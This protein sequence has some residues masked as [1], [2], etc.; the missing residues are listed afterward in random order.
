MPPNVSVHIVTY[1]T[2]PE[3]TRSDNPN[4]MAH[5]IASKTLKQPEE[6]NVSV[7]TSYTY[8]TESQGMLC[9]SIMS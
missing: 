7:T 1:L 5:K 4:S 3:L 6:T 9:K 2:N 8:S